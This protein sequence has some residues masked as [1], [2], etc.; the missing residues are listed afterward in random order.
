ME[1]TRSLQPA[2]RKH[3]IVIEAYGSINSGG[4]VRLLDDPV[5]LEVARRNGRTPAQV[6]LKHAL[7]HGHVILP[8]SVRPSRIEENNLEAHDF[9]LTP[10]DLARL[11]ALDKSER[12]YWGGQEVA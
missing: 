8:K 2:C 3:G 11:D 4:D 7:A 1:S 10:D 5:V 9:D 12:S 6:L